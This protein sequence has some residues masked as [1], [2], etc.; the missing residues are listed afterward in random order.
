MLAMTG[1]MRASSQPGLRAF[2]VAGLLTLAASL[3]GC[4]VVERV[5]AII[6]GDPDDTASDDAGEERAELVATIE[7]PP[8]PTPPPPPSNEPPP[9]LERAKRKL[10]FAA[11]GATHLGFNLQGLKGLRALA[12]ALE[13]PSW[14]VEGD[15]ET[16][17]MRD[18]DLRTTWI[19]TLDPYKPCALGMHLG[20]DAQLQG[21]RVFASAE[22]KAF[23]KHPRLAKVRVHT[24]DGWVDV[25]LPDVRDYA[26]VVFGKPIATTAVTIEALAYHGPKRGDLPIAEFEIFGIGG[27][28]R[29]P[30][31]LDPSKMV[32]QLDEPTWSK[33]RDGWTRGASFLER[34]AEDG[35]HTRVMPATAV[36]GHRDDRMQ[37]VEHLDSTD[38]RSHR[39]MYLLLDRQT[40][41]MAPLGDLGGLGGLLFRAHDGLGYVSGY[42][43]EESARLSGVVLEEDV[44]RH[45][46]TQRLS[47]TDGPGVLGDWGMDSEPM[48]RAGSPSNRPLDDCELG[49][50]ES[51][52]AFA[53]ATKAKPKS[54]EK[55]AEWMICELGSDV[56][57]YLSDHGPCG[58][59][60]D[61]VVLGPQG[62]IAKKGTSRAGARLRLQRRH[63][64]EL[65]VEVGGADDAVEM[66][67]VT[68]K[69]ITSLGDAEFAASAP[70][71][72]R[73]RC[74]DTLR[75]PTAP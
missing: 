27:S 63:G 29:E 36:F 18:D 44:L 35:S 68:P 16:G 6:K 33:S 2:G 49:S 70:A 26:Y 13:V 55:P 72:C 57:A 61:V 75:N 53:A 11:R 51:L 32:V 38:C 56:R 31:E 71:A 14:A 69:A 74:D 12:G 60:W 41:V 21:V 46:R 42:V 5:K 67:R 19:C 64:A 15:G 22:G 30:L 34:V 23:D 50:D 40:R 39:G 9:P 25:E 17:R 47:E 62:V 48:P 37:L 66:L 28:P 3:T 45:R 73:K 59:A 54:I 10:A 4:N 20:A 24:D 43:D 65:L 58:K 8:A 52:A 7:R 1:A